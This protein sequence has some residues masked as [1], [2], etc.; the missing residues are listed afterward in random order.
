MVHELLG[1]TNN[2]VSLPN[3]EDMKEVVLSPE[4]DEFYANV[5]NY[6]SSIFQCYYVQQTN[7]NNW[8]FRSSPDLLNVSTVRV[9]VCVHPKSWI[10]IIAFGG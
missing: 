2:R 6:S 9:C 8:N 4:Q 5:S 10:E 3:N 1:I 7:S